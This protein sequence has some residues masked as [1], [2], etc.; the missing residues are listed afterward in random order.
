VGFK[1]TPISE[2]N[3]SSI[4]HWPG[5][6]VHPD[7]FW[8]KSPLLTK[9]RLNRFLMI[10]LLLHF[11][12][13]I[14]QGLWPG[15]TSEEKTFNPIQVRYLEPETPEAPVSKGTIVDVPEPEKIEE[16]RTNELLSSFNSRAHANKKVTARK[17]YL[18]KKTVAPKSKGTAQKVRTTPPMAAVKPKEAKT[19]RVRKEKKIT[20]LPI[21]P[22]GTIRPPEEQEPV[23]SDP[24]QSFGVGGS[25]ALLDGFDAEKYASFDTNNPLLEDS[26]DEESISLDTRETKYASYFARI[27]NQIERVW[28]YPSEAAQRG[29]SG[30]LTL[31]FKISKDGN[32]LGIRLIEGSRHEV[33]DLAAIKA[34]KEAAPFYPFPLTIKKEKLAILATFVYSPN[35]GLLNQ[36]TSQR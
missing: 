15:S 7:F 34:I 30:E 29:V 16:P 11:F 14:F 20:P 36:G 31:R 4:R 21:L 22:D 33:L 24:S 9:T 18:R 5:G 12:A 10:S 3:I 1:V 35:Y 32:L 17:E 13:V 23:E 8:E 25:F 6:P 28:T 19:K 26:D 27:K 2:K